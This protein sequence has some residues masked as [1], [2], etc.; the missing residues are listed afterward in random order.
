MVSNRDVWTAAN[1]II[2]MYPEEP[3]FEAAQRADA[4]LAAGDAFNA[5]LWERVATAVR[6]LLRQ[7]PQSGV[8][9]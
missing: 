3:E 6:E 2:R 8:L 1:Q 7:K 9:N 5:Q 4:A